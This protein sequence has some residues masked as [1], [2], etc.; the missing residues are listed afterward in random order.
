MLGKGTIVF[1]QFP[2]EAR[3][4][5]LHQGT[6]VDLAPG[7]FQAIFDEDTL[8]LDAGQELMIYY[9]TQ[10]KF[11]KQ[12]VRVVAV[13]GGG[14]LTDAITV[15]QENETSDAATATVVCAGLAAALALVGECCSAESRQCYRVSTAVSDHRAEL[16]G[17]NCKLLDVSATGYAVLSTK[18]YKVGQVLDGAVMLRRETFRGRVCI[19]SAKDL[20]RGRFRYGLNCADERTRAGGLKEGLPKLTMDIQ[21]EQ[22]RRRSGAP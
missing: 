9:E 22:L 12:A 5:L 3:T 14:A 19:Q 18:V 1:L 10:R 20:G 6:V 8:P 21:L 11:V 15:A 4:R 16:A 2:Q 13:H 7:A 17:E